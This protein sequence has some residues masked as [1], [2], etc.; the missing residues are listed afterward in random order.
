MTMNSYGENY[1]IEVIKAV[2]ASIPDNVV[3]FSNIG[4]TD[5]AYFRRLKEAGLDGA[6]HVIRLGEGEFTS[7]T[8][9]R[10]QRTI[11]AAVEAGLRIQDCLEPIG[12]EHTAEELADHL[13]KTVEKGC[14]DS[15]VMKRIAVPGT[16]F[17]DPNGQITDLRLGLITAVNALAMIAVSDYPWI[18]IHEANS[19]GLVS[20]GNS[21]C[22]ETGI[23]PRDTAA[24]T[25]SGRGLD[26]PAVRSMFYEAGF[27]HLVRGGGSMVDLTPDY[28]AERR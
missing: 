9:E 3:L 24:D 8:P 11:D 5:V 12:A 17:D 27:K 21:I 10:R 23:N 2:R 22:A 4:D 14:K 25:A 15:G 26:V 13:F 18:A 16:P 6:Y 19:I 20:G 28:M 1:F 7:I